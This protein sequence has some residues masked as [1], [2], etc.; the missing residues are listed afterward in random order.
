MQMAIKN[1]PWDV[2]TRWNSTFDMLDFALDY[3]A[4]VDGITDRNKLGL[5][6]YGLNNNEWELLKQLCDILKV[7]ACCTASEIPT[8]LMDCAM[9]QILK[10]ATHYFS[11]ST[12][13][14]AMVIPAMNYIDETFTTGMLND[15]KLNPAIRAAIGLA[16]QTLNRYYLLTDSFELY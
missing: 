14:L 16:K 1:L 3:W 5:S 10:D 7:C 9:T 11:H 15:K 8:L 12:P 2:V 4:G 6:N 13:N